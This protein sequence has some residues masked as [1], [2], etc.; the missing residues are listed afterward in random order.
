MYYIKN[1]DKYYSICDRTDIGWYRANDPKD[2]L[3]WGCLFG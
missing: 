2:H 1:N 3:N